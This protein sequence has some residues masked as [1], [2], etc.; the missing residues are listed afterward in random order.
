MVTGKVWKLQASFANQ[1]LKWAIL[2]P[3]G[4]RVK[5]AKYAVASARAQHKLLAASTD[6]RG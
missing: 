5:G 1:K 2:R 3:Y 6:L 4:L